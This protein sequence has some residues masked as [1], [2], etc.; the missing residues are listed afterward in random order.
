MSG[1]DQNGRMKVHVGGVS[2]D[3]TFP[4]SVSNYPVTQSVYIASGSVG[5][6][7]SSP[8]W[9]TGSVQSTAVFPSSLN[10]TIVTSSITQ[11]VTGSI[12]V[13]NS[14]TLLTSS[15]PVFVTNATITQSVKIDQS[16]TLPVSISNFPS[17]QTV[18]GTITVPNLV[19][20][21]GSVSVLNN[22][23][24]AQGPSGSIPWKVTE[25]ESATFSILSLDTTIGN[26][27]SM[28][29]ILNA[30][31]SGVV[32]K[33]RSIKIINTQNS[34]VTGIVSNFRLLRMTN[35]SAGTLLT[36]QTL[37]TQD[38]LN[39]N[40][41]CRTGATITGASS[42]P[43]FRYEWSS[44]EWGPGTLDTESLEHSF[45]NT[46]PVYMQY[47][48]RKPITLR[49]GEGITITHNTNSTAGSFDIDINFTQE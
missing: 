33:I 48:G 10:V 1:F 22:A 16:T 38:S 41:T 21:T 26:G 9:V 24:V 29:S 30:A 37:D 40:V 47:P 3:A 32:I 4:V 43:L 42:V 17:I 27:K 8:F 13:G 14:I 44:D 7:S 35:H 15:Q 45:Q 28:L 11:S 31:G 25:Y 18:T 12:T 39:E 19:N 20:I 36:A 46:N 2:S 49:P 34:A 6:G 23:T 5:F